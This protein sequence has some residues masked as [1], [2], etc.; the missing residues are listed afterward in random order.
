MRPQ[1]AYDSLFVETSKVKKGLLEIEEKITRIN[2]E[3]GLF[4]VFEKDRV[5]ISQWM[6]LELSIVEIESNVANLELSLENVNRLLKTEQK[7][8]PSSRVFQR[9]ALNTKLDEY[10]IALI[11]TRQNF[12]PDSPEVKKLEKQITRTEELME[13]QGERLLTQSIL[14]RNDAYIFLETKRVQLETELSALK[15]KLAVKKK[16]LG[17]NE[18]N[19]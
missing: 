3:N 8:I 13:E 7:E 4:L 16:G 12:K 19:A 10:K 9:N 17:K 11:Q 14:V 2:E 6:T 1:K 15:A 18:K 5:E